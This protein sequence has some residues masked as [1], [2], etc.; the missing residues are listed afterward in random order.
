MRVISAASFGLLSLVMV[1]CAAPIES[2]T[3]PIDEVEDPLLYNTYG[4]CKQ[5]VHDA[6]F[7]ACVSANPLPDGTDCEAVANAAVAVACDW[8][9]NYHPYEGQPGD[10]NIPDPGNPGLGSFDDSSSK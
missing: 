10:Y 5:H 2:A 7:F 1:G 4:E 9:W 6:A 3:E 8:L